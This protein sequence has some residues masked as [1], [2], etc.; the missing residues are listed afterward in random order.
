VHDAH[1][2]GLP[3]YDRHWS[4]SALGNEALD[5]V[6]ATVG[7]ITGLCFQQQ[8]RCLSLV[9][10]GAE[11]TKQKIHVLLR[12][13]SSS[14]PSAV[15]HLLQVFPHF[16]QAKRLRVDGSRHEWIFRE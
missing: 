5:L 7:R 2:K 4:K 13:V 1:K 15:S 10:F 9:A 8:Q 12:P 11:A 6:T 14:K 3:L 16:T